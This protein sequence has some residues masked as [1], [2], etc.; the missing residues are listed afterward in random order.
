MHIE[1]FMAAELSTV[2]GTDLS[3]TSTTTA[4]E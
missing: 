1:S 2:S 3:P 4:C